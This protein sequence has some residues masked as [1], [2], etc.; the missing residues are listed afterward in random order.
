MGRKEVC[1]A[2]HARPPVPHVR[3]NQPGT[4]EQSGPE[5]TIKKRG[6]PAPSP[7]NARPPR[8]LFL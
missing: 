6:G 8:R 4:G 7:R 3:A 5:S 1:A 2:V